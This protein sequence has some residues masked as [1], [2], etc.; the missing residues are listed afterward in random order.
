MKKSVKVL[1][2]LGTISLFAIGCDRSPEAIAD[3]VVEKATSK[4]DLNESQVEKLEKIKVAYLEARKERESKKEEH[5]NRIK[6]YILSDQLSE[7]EVREQM[8]KHQQVFEEKFETF[9]PLIQDF[10]A[11]LNKEQKEKVLKFAE[12]MKDKHRRYRHWH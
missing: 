7:N 1:A 9:F 6:G 11:S 2:I 12:K 8:T 5:F 10:H 4:L 3:K